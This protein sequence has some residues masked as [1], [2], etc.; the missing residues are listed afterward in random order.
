MSHICGATRLISGV[1]TEFVQ[2]VSSIFNIQQMQNSEARYPPVSLF[3]ELAP[4]HVVDGTQTELVRA[5]WDEAPNSDASRLWF[6]VGQKH[7]PRGIWG[8]QDAQINN[9]AAASLGKITPGERC[10]GKMTKTLIQMLFLTIMAHGC[11][12]FTNNIA[13]TDKKQSHLF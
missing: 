12:I 10:G 9:S 5:R 3:A 8:G 11:F 4:A 2:N 6:D 7:R 1:H 13:A